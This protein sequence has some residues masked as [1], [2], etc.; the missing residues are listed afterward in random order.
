[1]VRQRPARLLARA[2]RPLP[3]LRR[4][5]PGALSRGRAGHRAARRRLLLEVRAHRGCRSSPRSSASRSWPSP[6]TDSSTGSS[7][8]GSCC[9]QPRS[10]S[11]ANTALH[12]SPEWALAALGASGFLFAAA[13]AYPK[14]MGMGD[15]KLALLMG[16]ALGRTVP[17]RADARHARRSSRAST[18]SPATAAPPGRWGSRSGR[19]WPSARWSPCS[20]AMRSSA[21]WSIGH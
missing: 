14:G 6:A 5:D 3:L 20:G 19:S 9:P 15:V 18:C 12:P 8:T 17:G 4:A 7:R 11:A 10:C 13:L 1:M 16:A 2:S 21:Y